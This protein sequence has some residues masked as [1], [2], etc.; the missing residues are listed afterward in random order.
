MGTDIP[1]PKI[2]QNQGPLIKL[3]L[4]L[5]CKY[6]YIIYI[7]THTYIIYTFTFT[8]HI[9]TYNNTRISLSHCKS[10]SIL[11]NNFDLIMLNKF[12]YYPVTYYYNNLQ[13]R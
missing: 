2:F 1:R 8:L 3:I 9:Y 7:I 4:L 12:S 6:Y 11:V 5:Y 13:I 10:L